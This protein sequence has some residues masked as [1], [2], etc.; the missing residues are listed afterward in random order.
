V[1]ALEDDNPNVR[2]AVAKALVSIRGFATQEEQTKNADK[3]QANTIIGTLLDLKLYIGA[4][5]GA[6]LLLGGLAVISVRR[7]KRIPEWGAPH[8]LD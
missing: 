3:K 7:R 1:E 6:V 8:H 5:A 2:E 4:G